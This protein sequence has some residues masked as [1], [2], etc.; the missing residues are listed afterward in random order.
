[1]A[2]RCVKR[3]KVDAVPGVLSNRIDESLYFGNVWY[4]EDLIGNHVR[5]NP[6]MTD[7]VLMCS[8]VNAIYMSALESLGAIHER[9][10]DVDR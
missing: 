7:V 3:H 10:S 8:A 2:I 1:M 6:E 5:A 4:L 9:L